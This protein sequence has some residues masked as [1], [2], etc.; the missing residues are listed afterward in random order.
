MFLS[1][2]TAQTRNNDSLVEQII[3]FHNTQCYSCAIYIYRTLK[4][5]FIV[6]VNEGDG[7]T[8]IMFCLAG[9]KFQE[10]HCLTCPITWPWCPYISKHCLAYSGF[11]CPC[12]ENEIWAMLFGGCRFVTLSRQKNAAA[13]KQSYMSAFMS[14]I[15]VFNAWNFGRTC[16][17][18]MNKIHWAALLK[19]ERQ[20][21][22]IEMEY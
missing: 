2:H 11:W 20:I 12:A 18:D 5:Y 14:Y 9:L 17:L 10:S 8:F 7:D 16:G 13:V 19:A 15:L 4:Y 1:R 3:L 6:I 22:Y 21:I